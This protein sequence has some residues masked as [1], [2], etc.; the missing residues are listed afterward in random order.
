MSSRDLFCR[1]DGTQASSSPPAQGLGR[2]ATGERWSWAGGWRAHPSS[3]QTWLSEKAFISYRP[4]PGPTPG[5]AILGPPSAPVAQPDA[6]GIR[7]PGQGGASSVGSTP[8]ETG[9]VSA[10]AQDHISSQLGVAGQGRDWGHP[11]GSGTRPKAGGGL[12][13]DAGGQAARVLLAQRLWR[14][15]R[16]QLPAAPPRGGATLARPSPARPRRRGSRCFPGKPPP[17][18]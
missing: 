6:Q 18:S 10:H 3:T 5:L 1:I 14:R 17:M 15:H 2:R 16:G 7:K 13:R 8:A 4:P 11:C 9:L 12:P